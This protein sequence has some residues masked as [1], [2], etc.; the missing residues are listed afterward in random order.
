MK[1]AIFGANGG[2]G[3]YAVQHALDAGY[4]VNAYVRKKS[5]LLTDHENLSV[6]EGEIDD[7]DGVN[8]A[9][10]DCQAVFGVLGYP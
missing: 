8:Q 9:V 3:K 1:V 10:S 4:K 5:K 7:Y 6:I 2:I